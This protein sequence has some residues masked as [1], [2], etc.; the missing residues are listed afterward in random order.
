VIVLAVRD[1]QRSAARV[2]C[3]AIRRASAL[4]V[5]GLRVSGLPVLVGNSGSVGGPSTFGEPHAEDGGGLFGQWGDPLLAALARG[6]GVRARAEV[7][8]AAAKAGQL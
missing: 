8:V 2:A 4:R 1:G 6:G 7:D 3:L 5:S